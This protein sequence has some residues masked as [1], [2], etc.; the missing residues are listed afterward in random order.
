MEGG[1][2]GTCLSARRAQPGRH[3]QALGMVM[4]PPRKQQKAGRAR[5]G[6]SSHLKNHQL[7][8]PVGQNKQHLPLCGQA[9]AWTPGSSRPWWQPKAPAAFMRPPWSLVPSPVPGKPATSTRIPK[10]SVLT[11]LMMESPMAPSPASPSQGLPAPTAALSHP[12]SRVMKRKKGFLSPSEES[13]PRH[14]PRQHS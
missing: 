4:T 13:P 5:W 12:S 3:R 9:P 7:H 11:G 8:F 14:W 6:G 10:K 2:G 1:G